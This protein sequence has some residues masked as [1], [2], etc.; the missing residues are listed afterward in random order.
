M[1][2]FTVCLFLLSF[3][4]EHLKLAYLAFKKR[5]GQI[6]IHY[7]GKNMKKRISLFRELKSQSIYINH[8]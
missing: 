6:K 5:S 8:F 1:K 7:F 4:L 3:E 2:T